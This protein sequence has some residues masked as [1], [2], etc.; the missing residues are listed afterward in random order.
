MTFFRISIADLVFL[1]D[2]KKS[3]AHFLE[4]IKKRYNN[5]F[6]NKGRE[7]AK[8]D[9]YLIKDL[10]SFSCIEIN[11]DIIVGDGFILERDEAF[12]KENIYCFE[13]F[14]R[15]FY[16]YHLILNDGVLL[17]SAGFSKDDFSFIFVGKS[18][19]GKTTVSNILFR[20]DF[21]IM[22]D[23]VCALRSIGDEFYLYSTPFWGNF[24]KPETLNI[25]RELNLIFFPFRSE[26]FS[27]KDLKKKDAIKR[28]L[29]CVFNFSKEKE[30]SLKVFDFLVRLVRRVNHKSIYFSK[31][32]SEL[33][34]YLCSF[35]HY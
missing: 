9:M 26:S 20:N 23:E 8:I 12:I 3:S 10:P 27:V 4:L 29:S 34:R 21:R 6:I 30:L 14:L 28:L 17:H 24:K 32:S 5:F 16:S 33:V 13:N 19:S 35:L 7:I 2:F 11:K 1:L 31:D 22:S 25:S 15:V 18:G